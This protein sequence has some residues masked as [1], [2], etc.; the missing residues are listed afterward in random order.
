M[1]GAEF[2]ADLRRTLEA[3]SFSIW[4]D[5]VDLKGDADWWSQNESALQS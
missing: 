2:A 4:Q 3:R 1:H 5:I